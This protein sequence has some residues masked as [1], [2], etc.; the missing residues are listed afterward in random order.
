MFSDA[1][2]IA[3]TKANFWSFA[4][5]EGLVVTPVDWMPAP[6]HSVYAVYVVRGGE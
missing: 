6:S 4:R 2:V 5:V 3:G 1:E